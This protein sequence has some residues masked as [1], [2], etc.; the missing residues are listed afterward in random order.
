MFPLLNRW[1]FL[2]DLK[3][4]GTF[5]LLRH[6]F[7]NPRHG[8]LNLCRNNKKVPNFF[9]SLKKSHLFNNAYE[10]ASDCPLCCAFWW[11]SST[12]NTHQKKPA[13]PLHYANESR[14]I[15]KII[16]NDQPQPRN[17]KK[18][19]PKRVPVYDENFFLPKVARDGVSF[20]PVLIRPA[21]GF[22]NCNPTYVPHSN[23]PR[24][25]TNPAGK[26]LSDIPIRRGAG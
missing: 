9:R 6:R 1:L 25:P 4:F 12:D 19:W 11:T 21:L 5:L 24:T 15:A 10:T 13:A 26:F 7:N 23:F 16:K 8:L 14:K 3:K 22:N 17:A 2:R 20:S 18:W